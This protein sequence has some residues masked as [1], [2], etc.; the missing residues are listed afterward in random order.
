MEPQDIKAELVRRKVK[1]ADIA[2]QVGHSAPFVN[3]VISRKRRSPA[4]EK[5]VAEAIGKP[6][7]KVFPEVAA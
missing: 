5:A 3:D 1:Q 7:K 4:I 2:R 6:L